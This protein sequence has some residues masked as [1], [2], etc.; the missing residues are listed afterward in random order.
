MQA[1]DVM[2]TDIVTVGPD[3]TVE[4]VAEVLHER[5]ISAAPV[6][7]GD[8]LVGI[9]S[10]NDLLRS[11]AAGG[12]KRISLWSILKDKTAEFTRTHGT[13]VRD[14]MTPQVLTVSE[15][16]LLPDVAALLESHHVKRVPVMRGDKLV[17]IVSRADLLRAMVAL[18][19]TGARPALKDDRALRARILDALA[20]DTTVS[21]SS[22]SVIVSNGLVYLWGIA[23][24]DED[25]NAIRVAAEGSA[26]ADKVRDFVST[27]PSVLRG[28]L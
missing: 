6:V 7:S 10:E 12:S 3:D 19:P 15:D 28:A 18:S 11:L 26:G 14:V 16:A 1:R 9:V 24:T 5:R 27:L 20:A 4:S 21:M 25:K 17:G 23:E 8:Q 13:R 2:T 22:V